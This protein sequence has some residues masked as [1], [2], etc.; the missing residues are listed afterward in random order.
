MR[1]EVN[2]WPCGYDPDEMDRS[3]VYVPEGEFIYGMT[4]E[5]KLAAARDGGVHPDRL[6]W[7]SDYKVMKTGGFW[8]DKYP[9]TR[10][11]FARFMKETRYEIIRFG[12]VVGWQELTHSWPPDDPA[13]AML[14]VIGVNADDAEAYAR[15]AGKRLP[16]EAEW[17]KA[18]R[19][20]DGR[21]YPWGD[22]FDPQACCLSGGNLAFSAA[23]PVGSWPRGASPYGAMDMEGLV[24]QYVRTLSGDPTH[25]LAGSS[26][27]H[28]QKYSYMAACR[29]GWTP[30]M[31]NYV[32]GFRCASDRPP[33]NP[34]T[35]PRYSPAPL[36]LPRPLPIRKDL[37]LNQPIT[38]Q[39][40][41]CTTL[42]INVPWFPES[43]W[44]LDCPEIDWGPFAGANRWPWKED[45]FIDWEVSP[46]GRHAAYKRHAD[47]CKQYFDA[48][49]EGHTVY[50][51]F[52]V[53]IPG[54]DKH[55]LGG[56]CLKNISPF[57]SSQERMTLGVV[58][59][60]KPRMASQMPAPKTHVPFQCSPTELDPNNNSVFL[61]SYDG[62]AYVARVNRPP[63]TVSSNSSIP[64]LH[65]F[66]P[67]GVDEE[68]GKIV[69]LVG[70]FEELNQE[71][72]YPFETGEV[73][74]RSEAEKR[75]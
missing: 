10:G 11:Q 66:G 18:A 27:F 33:E 16:T 3:M 29:H 22:E 6:K 21:L 12:W 70:S 43:V 34:V 57:F 58:I 44:L 45:A 39:G 40:T 35:N 25:L 69:F 46:D 26:L 31:R 41:E 32:S 2:K 7:H 14:P 17:E 19:G 55:N 73:L 50:Y 64:C 63:C 9:V 65:L 13:Q 5:Q 48:W 8:I 54:V 20:T 68:G 24:C 37:Y 71:L 15:W 62:T 72:V 60:G 51:R 42:Q 75:P 23:F 36:V 52:Q 74:A 53:E 47:G 67:H 30:Q 28:I 4:E 38:L 56:L 49:V 61:R 1:S 59:D